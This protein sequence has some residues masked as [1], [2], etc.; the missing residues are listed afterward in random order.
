MS[1]SVIALVGD[2]SP[3]VPAHVAIPKALELARAA[4][5]HNIEWRWFETKNLRVVPG[6][7]AECAGIWV[8][9][10][11]PYANAA[12]V[13]E[14][15]RWARENSQPFLG[16]CGGF[17]HALIEFARNVAGLHRADH[18]ESAPGAEILLVTKLACSLVEKSGAVRFVPG[19]R[20][21]AAYGSDSATEGYRCSYGLNMAYRRVLE[22]AGLRFTVFDEEDA[23]R[24]A[25][26]PDHPFF[27]G[28][29]FQ[30][31]RAALRGQLP[32]IVKAFVDATASAITPRSAF[33][34]RQK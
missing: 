8:V 2:Y 18:A 28:T 14:A 21:R 4:G 17:Q 12:G 20:L 34:N 10:G 16:T 11:S 13:L 23:V 1:Q 32:P 24:G 6:E 33:S 26:L 5:G 19:S 31:E 29:L 15:I 3:D 30:P 9:P 27:V 25:E 7:L 22:D